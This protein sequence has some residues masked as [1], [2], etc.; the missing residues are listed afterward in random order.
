MKNI[1]KKNVRR[2][3]GERVVDGTINL[4]LLLVGIVSIYPIWYVLIASVS[5]PVAI[6]TGKV[7]FWP[8]GF[9]LDG[10][11]NL[12]KN[13]DIWIGY[14]NTILYTAAGTAFDMFV[15][16]PAAYALSRDRLPGRK[17][18]TTLFIITM[19]VSGGVIPKY[20]LV[21][22]L[23][24][25]NSPLSLILPSCISVFNIIVARSFFQG[26]IPESLFDAAR[27]DGCGYTRFFLQ[28]VLKLS[29]ALLAI[30]ALYCI[31]GHWNTYLVA[32]MYLYDK[33][34]FTLQQIIK[35]ITANLDTSLTEFMDADEM[36]QIMQEKQLLKYSVIVVSVI[37]MVILYP[38]IQKFFVRGVMI[39]AVKG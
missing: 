37:P 18:I 9:N 38:F 23:G 16:I 29:P 28:V 27:I 24:L 3:K 12:I 13:K 5:S 39:G 4:L 11:T 30:I 15:Q 33:E 36:L 32:E 34:Y 2:K 21:S 19:Y 31:Q 8:V 6:S 26:S 1:H 17:W 22:S 25:I 10:Y 7:L 35:Q 14:R 20:L